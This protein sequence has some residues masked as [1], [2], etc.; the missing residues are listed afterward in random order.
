M[1][2]KRLDLNGR[3]F[4]RLLVTER[5]ESK[6]WITFWKVECKCGTLKTVRTG[7]LT[8]GKIV[9][10][11]CHSRE[12]ARKSQFRHGGNGTPLHKRWLS[13][14]R[15]CSKKSEDA[16]HYYEK[17]IA[18]C[19]EWDSF[20]VFRRDM[21]PTFKKELELDRIDNNKGYSKENCRW[22]TH[23]DNILNR[24]MTLYVDDNGIKMPAIDYAKKYTINYGTLRSRMYR[25]R[26]R[27]GN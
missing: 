5:A 26:M 18:I 25:Q 27:I 22:V 13:M 6:E 9:S 3:T 8:S 1:Q 16:I 15:R 7:D 21:G 2:G 23:R 24:N 4:G 12:A 14:R 19:K 10:C 11:G 17:G 20:D